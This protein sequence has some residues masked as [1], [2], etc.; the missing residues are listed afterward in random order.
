M[1]GSGTARWQL[2]R[3]AFLAASAGAALAACGRGSAPAAPLQTQPTAVPG[4]LTAAI[5]AAEAARPH[6]GETVSVALNPGPV[7]VDLGGR[8][9]NTRGYADTVPGP[10][11]RANVGD[12][13]KATVT[14]KLD[15]PTSVHWHGIALRNNMDGV[16][17]ATA[18]I[19]PGGTFTYEFSVPDAGTYWAHPHTGVN[20]D[21]GLYLPLIIDDPKAPADYDAE[22][23]VVLDDWT[24][25]V[26]KSPEQIYADLR[27]GVMNM[28][29]GGGST[30]LGGD[31]GDVI[32]PYYLVNGRIPEAPTTFTAKP[33]QRIRLRIINAGADTAFRIAL[34]G[35][36]MTVTHTDGFPV[37]PVEVDGL[38]LGMGERYDAVVT[39]GDGVFP[40]VALAEGKNALARALLTTGAGS[41]PEPGFQ[42]PELN[43]RIG[44]VDMF[45]AA[46]EARLA[47]SKAD[48]ELTAE[49]SGDMMSY[50]WGVNGSYPNNKPFAIEQGQQ[51]T[52]TF[53]NTTSMWHPMHLHGHTFAV[54]NA[55]GQLGARKDTVIVL[56]KQS[57]RIA[58]VA[59]N[60]G[61][62][63][64]HCHNTYHAEAGMM[65]TFDYLN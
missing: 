47:F 46:S 17:P 45:T 59:D 29:G 8:V 15:G 52:M 28:V 27:K 14:N 44:T 22:W 13:I 53:T 18:N 54:M 62:W 30:L 38:L 41:A 33:G 34:A 36:R 61:Y 5:D 58:I 65:S 35:H 63:P 50:T 51:A 55:K 12:E 16:E 26:G 31:A 2:S 43:G 7:T 3:R 1:D 23:I 37:E 49:L 21:T 64:L 32:Y 6:T 10:L 40:L 25:G 20:A 42:P 48:T 9:V 24:D 56:P 60:P 57:V 4:S 39:A 19:P 11:I